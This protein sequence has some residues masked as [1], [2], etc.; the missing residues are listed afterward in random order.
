[1]AFLYFI[2]AQILWL[3]DDLHISVRFVLSR[4]YSG[5]EETFVILH[6]CGKVFELKLKFD[7]QLSVHVIQ[8]DFEKRMM[9]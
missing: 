4:P 6:I 3:L 7:K 8:F 9:P 5:A 1:M 2:C